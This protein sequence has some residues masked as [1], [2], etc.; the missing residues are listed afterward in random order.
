M[1]KKNIGTTTEKILKAKVEELEM[2]ERM[3]FIEVYSEFNKWLSCIG[4]KQKNSS[5]VAD[6]LYG[7][8]E[9]KIKSMHAVE[10]YVCEPLQ[11]GIRFVRDQ[12][13]HKFMFVGEGAYGSNSKIY[14]LEEFKKIILKEAKR[15][16]N[17]KI[18]ELKSLVN[19]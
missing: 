2:K 15:L 18:K 16:K 13:E 6:Y 5:T 11:F 1:A 14:S 10:Y 7:H 8:Y 9:D 4:F 12:Y 19:I 17:E 3:R